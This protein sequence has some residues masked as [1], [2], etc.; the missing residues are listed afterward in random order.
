M[1]TLEI[2]HHM[3]QMQ[4]CRCY[5]TGQKRILSYKGYIAGQFCCITML[6]LYVN[7]DQ[8]IRL[9]QKT[10]QTNKN[11]NKKQRNKKIKIKNKNKN[12]YG[13]NGTKTRREYLNN[14]KVERF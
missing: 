2:Y 7:H 11:K 3:M 9:E 8:V 14:H 13:L 1:R 5:R 6:T 10:K 12:K 4:T